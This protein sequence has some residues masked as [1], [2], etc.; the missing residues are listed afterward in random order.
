MLEDRNLLLLPVLE[1]AEIF[2]LQ[3]THWPIFLISDIDMHFSKI[4]VHTE[5][6]RCILRPQQRHHKK[7]DEE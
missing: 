4:D 1:N 6:K 2:L 5:F 7:W 3:V